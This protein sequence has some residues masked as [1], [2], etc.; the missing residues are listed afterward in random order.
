[1]VPPLPLQPTVLDFQRRGTT[2]TKRTTQNFEDGNTSTALIR[3]K[4]DGLVCNCKN[5]CLEWNIPTLHAYITHC[6]CAN[7][8]HDKMPWQSSWEAIQIHYGSGMAPKEPI[9]VRFY[10]ANWG[11]LVSCRPEVSMEKGYISQNMHDTAMITS[12]SM[13]NLVNV[14]FYLFLLLL[15]VRKNFNNNSANNLIL[16]KI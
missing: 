5:P 14:K 11:L 9:P 15:V 4:V 7:F 6:C 3:T 10:E 1:M 13:H 16:P 12:M 2:L 8:L